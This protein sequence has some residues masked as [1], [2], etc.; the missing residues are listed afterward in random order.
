MIRRTC[1]HVS[2]LNNSPRRI[3]YH[4][5]RTERNFFPRTNLRVVSIFRLI[6]E[7][8]EKIVSFHVR[9]KVCHV[10][11]RSHV[12]GVTECL[13]GLI[14]DVDGMLNGTFPIRVLVHYGRQNLAQVI[15]VILFH[16]RFQYLRPSVSLYPVLHVFR[17]EREITF[18]S[19]DSQQEIVFL[20]SR[21][22]I[23]LQD[24]AVGDG[25]H[26]GKVFP[27]DLIRF[28]WIREDFVVAGN[29]SVP[30]N[31]PRRNIMGGERVRSRS[32]KPSFRVLKLVS[33]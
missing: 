29:F 19:D 14:P 23:L 13:Q 21:N 32:L 12:H 1:S 25:Y 6:V 10:H 20:Q 30:G 31:N 4:A 2:E 17:V 16:E 22:C 7:Y 27:V 28:G 11:H 8:V 5:I 26:A 3:C 9:V 15:S 33:P 18:R 24:D